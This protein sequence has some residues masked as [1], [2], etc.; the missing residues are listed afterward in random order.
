MGV[1]GQSLGAATGNDWKHLP[2]VHDKVVEL[3]LRAW[4]D[5][6]HDIF[7]RSMGRGSISTTP[8]NIILVHGF[9]DTGRVFRR[10][11]Q[12]LTDAG[13]TCSAPTLR[14]TDARHGLPDLAEKLARHIQTTIEP[15]EPFALVGFSMGA[16]VAR[17]YLQHLDGAKTA[18]AFFTI[19]A[20]HRGAWT[21][22]LYP[23]LG[24]R[25]MRPGSEFLRSLDES[26]QV[27]NGLPVYCYWT[28]VDLMV[29]AGRS[30][31]EFAVGRRILAPLHSLMPRSRGV[32]QDIV[33]EL[34]RIEAKTAPAA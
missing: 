18:R 15:G 7:L 8:M 23:G 10:L 11:S 9:L 4:I 13:H 20:P 34:M 31:L 32:A 3:N 29:P 12:R 26:A 14:P 5:E 25:Q 28:P 30:T 24:T 6:S 2:I 1:G 16:I 21:A 33:A 19:S 27:L 22:Y 17:Y